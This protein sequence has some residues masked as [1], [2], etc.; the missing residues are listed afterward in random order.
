MADGRV[1]AAQA[2]GG[3]SP[4]TGWTDADRARE[5]YA[6]SIE[7]SLSTVFSYVETFG[8]DDLVLIVLGDHQPAR[9]VS[10]PD[11]GHDVPVTIIAKDPGVFAAI[12]SWQWEDGV[13]PSPSAPV[14]RMDEFRDRFADAFSG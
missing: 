5:L 9:I 3:E 6:Q 12:R 11:A 2:S 4:V 14:W 7:Y 10:G 13:H 1:F 8:D